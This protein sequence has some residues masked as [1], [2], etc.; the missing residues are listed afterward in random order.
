MKM[1]R[2]SAAAIE[3]IMTYG[4]AVL[5][6]ILAISALTSFGLLDPLKY[7]TESRCKIYGGFYCTDFRIDGTEQKVTLVL[8]NGLG[9]EAKDVTIKIKSE[10]CVGNG[11]AQSQ[12]KGAIQAI[13]QIEVSGSNN[14]V[15]GG[16]LYGTEIK[17][18]GSGNVFNPEPEQYTETL[19]NPFKIEDYR[20]G[21][22]AALK[23]QA[24]G[25]YYYI[26]GKFSGPES[27][28]EL[29][30]LYYVTEDVKLSKSDISGTYTI[31]AEGKIDISGSNQ[32][33]VSYIDNL[34]FF[35][36]EA[37][38]DA[39]KFSGS[40]NTFEGY[41]YAPNGEIKESGSNNIVTGGFLGA[42]VELAGSSLKI[43]Y[44][45]ILTGQIGGALY[46]ENPEVIPNPWINGKTVYLN[47][48]CLGKLQ[49]SFQGN[50]EAN[51]YTEYTWKTQYAGKHTAVG[52]VRGKSE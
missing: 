4:W 13:E 33:G 23:A 39:I 34:L 6:V 14:I 41:F 44:I 11:D 10:D 15:N 21:G 12:T 32:K 48:I 45:P 46:L 7:F 3:F 8:R 35:S 9:F 37:D 25:K 36:N 16:A 47:F 38:K 27:E 30:G 22:S 26:N 5:L 52:I 51:W 20:P 29:N 18:S 19:P 1:D 40:G 42:E 50:I 2:K 43:I 24:E 31:V 49:R 28:A 17:N